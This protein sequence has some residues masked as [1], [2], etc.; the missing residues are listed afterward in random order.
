MINHYTTSFNLPEYNFAAVWLR[1]QWY[2]FSNSA[3]TDVQNGGLTFVTGGGYT[4]SDAIQGHW[5]IARNDVFVGHTQPP[6]GPNLTG[7]NP[8]A[9]ESGPFNPITKAQGLTCAKQP[10]GGFAGNFCLDSKQGMIMLLT[11]FGNNQRFFNI[12]D[13]PAFEENNAYLDI[14]PVT[15]TGCSPGG[16]CSQSDWMYG[17]VSGVTKD[18]EGKCYLPNAAIGWKQPNGFYYPPAFHS[19]NLFF[20]KVP[21]FVTS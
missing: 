11:N 1:P 4:L 6:A 17:Q 10:D 15:I 2:L 5:A 13:G 8:Y 9:D 14:K 21:T 7:G 19:N 16:N 20:K 12:Y 18:P 3:V